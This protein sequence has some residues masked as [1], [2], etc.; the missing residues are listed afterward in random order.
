M[1]DCKTGE[2]WWLAHTKYN[3]SKVVIVVLLLLS[4]S[5]VVFV[6][7][8]AH[9]LL[10]LDKWFVCPN[11]LKCRFLISSSLL[12]SSYYSSFKVKLEVAHN[13]YGHIE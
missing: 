13:T 12:S 5:F 4:S 9:L 3:T 8:S 7:T 11:R 6:P 2:I 1:L 10:L